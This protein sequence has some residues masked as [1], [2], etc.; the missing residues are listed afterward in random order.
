M[1]ELLKF[2]KL[3]QEFRAVRRRI[4]SSR[5]GREEN[6]SEHS[7]QLAMVAWYLV[8][9]QNLSLNLP[10]VIKYA[11]T[12][13]LVEIYAGDT[14]AAMHKGF[15]KEQSTKHEREEVAAKKL[16]EEFPE[17]PEMHEL[18]AN[19]EIRSDPESRFVYAL[20]KVIPLLDIY[21]D[22]GY[23]WKVHKVSLEDLVSSKIDKVAVSPEV[24]KYFDEIVGILESKQDTLFPVAKAEE[25]SL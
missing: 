17:F 3:T 1:D 10:L 25:K 18:I 4:V 19:Y 15:E 8:N 9:T 6:D 7:Y 21:L 22:D 11:L 12:H 20:D 24:K 2:V 13:D 16:K 5:E 14:P 23:S